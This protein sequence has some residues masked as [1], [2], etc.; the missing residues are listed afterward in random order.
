MWLAGIDPP[1]DDSEAKLRRSRSLTY[2]GMPTSHQSSRD[3][4]RRESIGGLPALC[5]LSLV[6][7]RVTREAEPE[8]PWNFGRAKTVLRFED[9]GTHFRAVRVRLEEGSLGWPFWSST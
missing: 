7:V 5:S 9:P 6:E 4:A 3:V 8:E 2:R 1:P